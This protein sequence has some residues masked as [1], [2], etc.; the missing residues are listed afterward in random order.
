MTKGERTPQERAAHIE[1]L[2]A[3]AER[4]RRYRQPADSSE[5]EEET[6]AELEER[7]KRL[8]AARNAEPDRIAAELQ[9]LL[10]RQSKKQPEKASVERPPEELITPQER[11]VRWIANWFRSFF[12]KS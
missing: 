8:E 1:E 6:E 9:A 2:L 7:I 5:I 10:D 3:K 12:K 11:A 4:E